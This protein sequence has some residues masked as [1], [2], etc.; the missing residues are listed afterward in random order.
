[1]VQCCEK[2]FL[3]VAQEKTYGIELKTY[4]DRP[5]YKEALKQAAGYGKQLGLKEI[6]LIFFVGAIVGAI[7]DENR[8]KYEADFEDPETGVKVMPI[9]VEMEN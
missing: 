3:Q 5:G 7:D 4:T 9:F 2:L 1:V 6:S 8:K